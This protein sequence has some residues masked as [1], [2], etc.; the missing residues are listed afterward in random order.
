VV[1]LISQAFAPEFWLAVILASSIFRVGC[2]VGDI[3]QIVR[4][5]DYA[6]DNSAILFVNVVVPA[7]LG[8][9]YVLR[10]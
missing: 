4:N 3:M 8:T 1:G 7:F 5:H 10:A 6:V 9:A 2:G